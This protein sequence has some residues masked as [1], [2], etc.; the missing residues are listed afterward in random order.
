M[1]HLKLGPL[2]W[3][4]TVMHGDPPHVQGLHEGGP[5]IPSTLSPR[6]SLCQTGLR[7]LLLHLAKMGNAQQHHFFLAIRHAG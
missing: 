2:G 1:A 7:G 5:R 3:H 4:M 6:V